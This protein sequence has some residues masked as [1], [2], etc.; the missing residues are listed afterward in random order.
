MSKNLTKTVLILSLFITFFSCKKDSNDAGDSSTI[1]ANGWKI[2]SANYTTVFSMRNL[3]H[4]NS[5]SAFDAIP[6]ADNF[7]AVAV[8]FNNTTGIAAG[9]FKV[10]TKPNQSDLLANEIM[11]APSTGYSQS[12]GHYN[13][14]YVTALTETV[15]ATVTITGGKAKI[16][17]PQINIITYPITSTSTTSTFTGT[18]VEQ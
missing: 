6:T 9:T 3:S 10:V 17:V 2:G 16:V 13:K 8:V 4:P 11:V 5:I 18:I 15:D 1:P 14:Q 7:N 12:T